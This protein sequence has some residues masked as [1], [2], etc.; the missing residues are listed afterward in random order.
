MV[1]ATN[2]EKQD[3]V[4]SNKGT[5]Q[6]TGE[7]GIKRLI[8]KLLLLSLGF[9]P[10]VSAKAI[11]QN[12]NQLNDI[13][14]IIHGAQALTAIGDADGDG[15]SNLDESRAGTNPFDANSYPWLQVQT[16]S[17]QNL[18]L[19]WEGL[20]GKR[21]EL[22]ATDDLAQGSWSGISTNLNQI[23]GLSTLLLG[24]TNA[25][26]RFFRVSIADVDTDGDS[27][28]DWEEARLGFNPR[29]SHTDRS[30][31]TDQQRITAGL[32]SN[33][34]VTIST[35]DPNLYE[36]WPDGGLVAIR[37]SGGL[38]QITVNFNLGG[39]A[40]LNEDY[41]VN[42]TTS[43]VIPMGVR[44]VWL[45]LQ[46]IA[47]AVDNE[48][49]E[50]ITVTLAAGTGYTL[51]TQTVASLNLHNETPT[52]LPNPKD[53]AR[54]LIQA[55]FGPNADTD[56]DGIPENVEEV[57]Q[58]G[59]EGW[60]DDQFTR[61]VGRLQPFTEFIVS[62]TNFYTDRKQAA[63]WNRVMGV[64]KLR[65]DDTQTVLPD[66]LRQRVGFALSEIFVIS[67]RTEM[68]GGDPR[69][70]ANYYDMLLTNS[71]G[72]FSNLLF[73]VSM[74]PCM[75]IYLS[76]MLNRKPDPTN[77]IYPDENYAREVM[78]LF[79]IGLW[80][81]N[82]DGSR[83]LNPQGQPIPTYDNTHITEFAR[84]FTGLSFGGPNFF[85]LF[86][87]DFTQPMKLWDRYH[88]CEPKTL[89][90]GFTLPARTPTSS[91]DTGAAARADI[92]AAIGN[93]Y[94]HPNVGPFIGRQ[95]IQR[96]VTSNPSREYIARV[97]A[98]FNNNGQGVRG[99]MKAVIKAVLLDVE[100]RDP[101]MMSVPTYG[102]LREPLLRVVNF[103]TAFSAAA[104]NGYY[105]LSAFN[106]DHAQET[107]N[108]PSV[109]N[110]FQPSYSP[111]GILNDAGLVAPEFQI[112]NASTAISA[113]NYFA[114]ALRNNDLH[115]WG[116]GG[117]EKAVR[118][119]LTPELSLIL[120]EEYHSQNQP[121][122]TPFDTDPLLQ[123]L[124]MVLTGGTLS[125]EQFHIIREAV[126]QIPTN[127]WMWHK[128]RVW[129]AIYL[130]LTSPDFCVQR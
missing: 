4:V 111:P 68:V 18:R 58:L 80:E 29:S 62:V 105:G 46:P 13:W 17:G 124:D 78:Q 97:T 122:V 119:N 36:R 6:L 44:E 42:A 95:L 10:L 35:L 28:L 116:A 21:Y 94:N 98:A 69:G 118:L 85:T 79:S 123:R 75:G 63:W 100:A 60:I 114:N 109:F 49:T 108:A 27:I 34:T 71:F 15:V 112:I 110:F 11:D 72:N 25:N 19:N 70:M 90:N 8:A 73:E 120:P 1:S 37:R 54:F 65:P 77:N 56:N 107:L 83:K 61:P 113:P 53:A 101:Q 102:K 96:L 43:I 64:N 38:R 104:S 125:P 103:A 121:N 128:E 66:F 126:N 24:A 91:P 31:S 76:H 57:M 30:N 93:L 81:L 74:H 45:E 67:D 130:V 129:L 23:D 41:T 59:I 51:G 117:A 50:S 32:A 22:L 89:L 9:L 5:L 2:A 33:N 115:R 88:D 106:M 48:L 99:D 20:K 26:A 7:R 127:S 84:V 47:D 16:V 87:Q 52:S 82:E 12:G 40:T 92:S 3:N 39:S 55:S 86:P 14:E